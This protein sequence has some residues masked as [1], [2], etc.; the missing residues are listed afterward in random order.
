M[1][2]LLKTV[3]SEVL[4]GVTTKSNTYWDVIPFSLVEVVSEELLTSPQGWRVSKAGSKQS[5]CLLFH[6]EDNSSTFLPN[7]G[8]FLPGYNIRP[9]K[10]RHGRS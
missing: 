7:T 4:K 9:Q 1:D 2:Y 10:E 8:K 3:R 6:P 5:A